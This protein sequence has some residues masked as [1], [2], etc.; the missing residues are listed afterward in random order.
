VQQAQL[1]RRELVPVG[2]RDVQHAELPVARINGNRG[3]VTQAF[4]AGRDPLEPG[5]GNHVHIRRARHVAR[6]KRVETIAAPL[7][8]IGRVAPRWAA[9][10]AAATSIATA[11]NTGT[12]PSEAAVAP[13][14]NGTKTPEALP[15]LA[16]RPTASA[17][18][19]GGASACRSE[20][21]LGWLQ[22][23]AAPRMNA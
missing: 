13:N 2:A 15:K 17:P 8:A 10:S 23:T 18:R 19:P 1:I 9:G 16:R 3:V 21:M 11:Q 22:P 12:T 6:L 14:T 4:G 20:S 5:A 7:E